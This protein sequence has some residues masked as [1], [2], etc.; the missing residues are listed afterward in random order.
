MDLSFCMSKGLPLCILTAGLCFLT[1]P[2]L[3]SGGQD[4]PKMDL[5]CHV[6]RAS[7]RLSFWWCHPSCIKWQCPASRPGHPILWNHKNHRLNCSFVEH[8]VSNWLWAPFVLFQVFIAEVFKS[9]YFVLKCS[10]DILNHVFDCF[11]FKWEEY[12]KYILDKTVPLLLAVIMS[13][14]KCTAMFTVLW[15][16]CP[17]RPALW[18]TKFLLYLWTAFSNQYLHRTS[19]CV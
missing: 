16:G 6:F 19:E 1:T 15:A 8:K 17:S 14:Y 18:Q 7:V 9:I 10:S 5:V 13:S 4:K 3:W 12:S 2:S 11:S